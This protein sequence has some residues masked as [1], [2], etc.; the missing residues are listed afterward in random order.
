V[1]R[2]GQRLGTK[3][4]K[5]ERW[6]PGSAGSF[7]SARQILSP[8]FMPFSGMSLRRAAYSLFSLGR[9][10]RFVTT[11]APVGSLFV[12]RAMVVVGVHFA[13]KIAPKTETCQVTL[14][15][16]SLSKLGRANCEI[17][18]S[19]LTSKAG[20]LVITAGHAGR[21]AGPSSA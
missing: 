16:D 18:S 12:A 13:L 20:C 11:S 10:G 19:D 15:T 9:L 14:V 6:A 17:V 5:T 8:I 4:A 1:G 2:G 21:I 7:A 3:I